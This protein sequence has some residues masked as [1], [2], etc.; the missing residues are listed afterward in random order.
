MS[1]VISRAALAGPLVA[2]VALAGALL[3]TSDAGVPLRDPGGVSLRRFLIALGLAAVLLSF[4]VIVRRRTWTRK[5]LLIVL[6]AIVSFHITY[7]AYRN[8]KS[9]IPL[10]APDE[11]YD[12]RL[13]DFERSVFGSDPAELLHSLLGTGAS[14]HVLSAIYLL[15]F[16]FVPLALTGALVFSRKLESG[17]FF[18]TALALNWVLAAVSYRLL[19]ALGPIYADPGAFAELPATGVSR[20]QETLLEQRTEF[21]AD[22]N[23]AG[24]FQSIGAFAS[25]HTSLF[26]TAGIGAHLLGYPKG[27]RAAIWAGLAGTVLATVYF[28]WHYLVDDLAGVLI[29]VL[30]LG[31]ARALTGLHPRAAR[32]PVPVPSTSPA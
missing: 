22:P 19:P 15:F 4:D 27:V 3:A 26:V 14:A 28:G 9:V 31:L 17:L 30:S 25:L 5:S 24:G 7:F 8:V 6:A 12:R 20:L 18:A 23:A 11:L 2:A 32:Q 16:A 21:L 10:L 29:A 13:G 1:A